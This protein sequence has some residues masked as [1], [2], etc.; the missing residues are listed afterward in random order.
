MTSVQKCVRTLDIDNVGL[1]TRHNTF[2]QMAG[3]FSFGDYF[4]EGAIRHAWELVTGARDGRRLRLRPR[5]V[6]VT[7]YES[8]DEAYQLWQDVAGVPAERIQRR[9]WPGQLLGHGR[10]RPVR[11]VLGDLLR[12]RPGVRLGGWSGSRRRPLHR[13]LEPRVHAG[14]ARARRARSTVSAGRHRCR[15]QNI[16][17]GLG[18]ERVAF[19]LQGVD[20]VYETDL[21]P[22]DHPAM[23][24]SCRGKKYGRD[25]HI[26]DVRMRVIADH[27]PRRHVM[28]IS[29][30]VTPGNEGGG[31]V[32]RRL[33]RRAVRSA[34]L[35]GVTEPVMA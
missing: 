5:A 6:W 34:R 29:D 18:I 21:M 2:F 28:L 31:Y 24:S 15:K 35:L 33:I 27:T 22:A 20:N 25:A 30:G 17:T 11:S 32:L 19:L 16:D 8:D 7:V 4:K 14:H 13:D 1:T 9:G 3:N 12:P 10:A 23:P 26:D